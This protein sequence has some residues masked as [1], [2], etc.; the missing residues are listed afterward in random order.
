[1]PSHVGFHHTTCGRSFLAGSPLHAGFLGEERFVI[2]M[3]T[4]VVTYNYVLSARRACR[5]THHRLDRDATSF[6]SIPGKLRA[7]H[8]R[9]FEVRWVRADPRSV[10]N[11]SWKPRHVVRTFDA[12]PKLQGRAGATRLRN[13]QED[14]TTIVMCWSPKPKDATSRAAYA[15]TLYGLAEWLRKTTSR[16]CLLECPSL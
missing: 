6:I 14:I 15:E 7:Q 12:P 13:W 2:C 11:R 3:C 10:S 16:T 4:R 8:G 9:H 1:M 5:L